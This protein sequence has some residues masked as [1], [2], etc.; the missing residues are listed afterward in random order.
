MK[1]IAVNGSPKTAGNTYTAINAALEELEVNEIQTELLHIADSKITGCIDCGHCSET[2]ECVFGDNQFKEWSDKLYKADG[3]I[4]ASPVYYASMTGTMKSFLDCLFRQSQ[5]RFRHK[6]GAAISISR[7]SGE[8]TTF[9]QLN[10]YF[11]I[12]E[13]IVAPSYYWNSAHGGLPGEVLEDKEGIATI[14]NMAR[15]MSWILKMKEATKNN[16]I[17]PLP[18]ERT[19]TNF[20]R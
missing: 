8:I 16:V 3:I 13:M 17:P 9:D 15:N 20:I 1:V 14:K 19:F 4:F 6:V 11:L 7:R 5:G 10:K 2:G 12:S 18:Y